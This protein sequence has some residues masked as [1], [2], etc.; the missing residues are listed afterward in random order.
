VTFFTLVPFTFLI[1][2]WLEEKFSLEPD[3]ARIDVAFGSA[4]GSHK[5]ASV[6]ER[7]LHRL[8]VAHHF[9]LSQD[10]GTATGFHRGAVS[11]ATI[12]VT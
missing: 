5:P 4:T 3:D 8:F 12:L 11:F 1:T 2:D 6:C 10:C 7:R 9:G